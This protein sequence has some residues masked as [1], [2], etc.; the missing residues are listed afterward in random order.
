M[1]GKLSLMT[2]HKSCY[3]TNELICK[4][5]SALNVAVYQSYRAEKATSSHRIIFRKLTAVCVLTVALQ[6]YDR[7][8]VGFL[9]LLPALLTKGDYGRHENMT[10]GSW[11]HSFYIKVIMCSTIQ[12]VLYLTVA[13]G[14]LTA[15]LEQRYI[16]NNV[17]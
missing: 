5:D 13:N 1:V 12:L 3:N 17:G 11:H 8:C 7:C 14:L 6:C 4:C 16:S 2:T 15:A 9:N 10:M